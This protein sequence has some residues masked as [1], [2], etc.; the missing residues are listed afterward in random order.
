MSKIKYSIEVEGASITSFLQVDEDGIEIEEIKGAKGIELLED[1][2]DNMRKKL[3]IR[4]PETIVVSHF[5][6][7]LVDV[8]AIG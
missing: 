8:Y 1:L 5:D 3:R 4:K 6:G 7:D 2:L